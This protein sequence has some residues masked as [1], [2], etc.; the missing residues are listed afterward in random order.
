MPCCRQSSTT[1][2]P[3]SP[4]RRMC[5]IC[6][7]VNLLVRIALVLPLVGDRD[8][9]LYASG[10]GSG[11]RVKTIFGHESVYDLAVRHRAD[12]VIGSRVGEDKPLSLIFLRPA[13]TVIPW[14]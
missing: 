9:A 10:R 13:T 5:T 4:C 6:S 2:T 8:E 3:L 14:V 7:G 12:T 1:G 11:K